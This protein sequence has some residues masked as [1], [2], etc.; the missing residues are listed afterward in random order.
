MTSERSSHVR[1]DRFTPAEA[2]A[3][4]ARC[5]GTQFDPAVVS[6]LA[7]ELLADREPDPAIAA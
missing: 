7:D 2:L 6:A 3:E 5:A 1:R 4:L